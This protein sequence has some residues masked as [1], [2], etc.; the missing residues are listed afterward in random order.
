MILSTFDD[1]EKNEGK[2]GTEANIFIH[3]PP[4]D[5]PH[6]RQILVLNY[7]RF[8]DIVLLRFHDHLVGNGCA[9][10]C[11]RSVMP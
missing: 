11:K 4:P 9:R 7:Y 3:S 8:I 5:R 10:H 2:K 6:L 1:F